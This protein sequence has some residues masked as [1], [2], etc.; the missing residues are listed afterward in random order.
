MNIETNYTT[1][2]GKAVGELKKEAAK[3]LKDSKAFD[4]KFEEVFEKFDTNKDGKINVNEFVPFLNAFFVGGNPHYDLNFFKLAAL[5]NYSSAD[6]N[7]NGE[8]EKEEFKKDLYDR[9]KRFVHPYS[10]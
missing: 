1:E 6:E 2:Q 9:L 8:V 3:L 5:I 7:K 10:Y 4:A